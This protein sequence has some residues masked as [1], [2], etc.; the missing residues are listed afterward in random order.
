MIK[1]AKAGKLYREKQFVMGIPA[2]EIPNLA[3]S[4]ELVVVQGIIDA[5]F[6]EDGQII[7]LDYKTDRIRRGQEDVLRERY[8]TQLE[9][10]KK[11][12]QQMTGMQVKET[13]IYSIAI[14]QAIAL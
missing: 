5:W 9:Y 8:H 10:Y 11:A 2:K 3:E 6:V 7:L 1:A 14:Q 13:W 12:L 4:D